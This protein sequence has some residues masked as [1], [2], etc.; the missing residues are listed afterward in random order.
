MQ[1]V[2]AQAVTQLV[3]RNISFTPLP[4]CDDSLLSGAF[5]GV[6]QNTKG[7]GSTY[8]DPTAAVPN[9]PGV[10]APHAICAPQ[11]VEH[12]PLEALACACTAPAF[13]DP[14]VDNKHLAP[15]RE[16]DGCARCVRVTLEARPKG[17]GVRWAAR[18]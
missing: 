6:A 3:L 1:S 10:C 17:H 16:N 2:A 14:N 9:R 18:Q 4:G 8:A 5:S 7:C 11:L 15:Y 12:T 13:P